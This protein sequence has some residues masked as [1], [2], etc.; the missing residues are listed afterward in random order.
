MD[1]IG[2][3][4]AGVLTLLGIVLVWRSFKDGKVF[5][6]LEGSATEKQWIFRADNPRKFFLTVAQYVIGFTFLI[7]MFLW[8]ANGGIPSVGW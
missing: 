4:F 2:G 6:C 3:L 1:L 5:D 7:G 8:M